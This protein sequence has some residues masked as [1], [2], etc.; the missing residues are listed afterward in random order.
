MY[1]LD[2]HH[3]FNPIAQHCSLLDWVVDIGPQVYDADALCSPCYEYS[4]VSD[5]LGLSLF[6]LARDPAEFVNTYNETVYAFLVEHGE[7]L[8]SFPLFIHSFYH[9]R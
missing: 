5:G 4:V 8:G 6:V 9:L 2:Y 7:I 1:V 3:H